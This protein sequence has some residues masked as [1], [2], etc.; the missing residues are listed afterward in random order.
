MANI[1]PLQ[2]P[3]ING[4]I[5]SF[6]HVR[7]QIAGFDFTGGFKSIDYD[8]ERSREMVYSNSP[9]P[10]GKTLG[11][12][13][14]T[15]EAEVYYD[16]WSNLLQTVQQQLGPG[17]G[18]QSFAIYVSYVGTNLS[19]YTDTILGC[20][21]DSTKASNKQGSAALTRTVKF[22]PLKI[23]FNG[24]DDLEVPLQAPPQ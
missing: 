11:E 6:G 21:F 10:V 18:D 1:A 13:K 7:M 24:V 20:T 4:A 16:W 9:D 15:C 8:R 23:L 19:T 17:Y 2:V 14:Y 5:R 22:N 3:L 12:N